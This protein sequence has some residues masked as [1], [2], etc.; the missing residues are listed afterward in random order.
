MSSVKPIILN[1]KKKS[2][3]KGKI[4]MHRTYVYILPSVDICLFVCF[5]LKNRTKSNH[6]TPLDKDKQMCAPLNMVKQVLLVVTP[7]NPLDYK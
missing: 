6:P 7:V 4:Q 5:N 2:K 3:T 1:L